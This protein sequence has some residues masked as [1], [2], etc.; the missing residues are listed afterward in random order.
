MTS[1]DNNRVVRPFEW[2]PEW[3]SRWPLPDGLRPPADENDKAAML[4]YWT[5]VN[6]YAIHH[7]DKFFS[8][9]TPTDFRLEKRKVELFH[10]GS[11]AP[12][13]LPKDEWGTFLRFT[14]AVESPYVE[15]NCMNA[16]WFSARGHRAVILLPQ[17]NADGVSQNALCRVFNLLGI[18]A[19]RMS[20]PYHD[21]RRPTGLTRADYAVSAN[22]GRTIDATRQGIIDMRSCLDWLEQRG[23]SRL[24][25]VGTSLGSCYAFLAAAHDQRISVNVFNHAST[26]FGDVTWTGQ[27]TRHIRQGIEDVLTQDELRQVWM[28]ISPIV[29][30]DKFQRWPRKSLMIYGRYDLTFLPEFSAQ[31]AGEFLRRGLDTTIKALP[32]G[33]YSLGETP[34]KYMDAWHI[35]R[36]LAK[37]FAA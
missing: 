5:A 22:I 3:A 2:G 31:T 29:Y 13:K 36:F 1:R 4:A 28:C 16:R 17:W 14:S 30:F 15:N 8:Y 23:Y 24:G 9:K 25:L 18:S 32:C 26:S 6:D 34:Y 10:T 7:S 27:S 20:M 12:K 19:L 35:S 11:D 37:A 33:H 21:I